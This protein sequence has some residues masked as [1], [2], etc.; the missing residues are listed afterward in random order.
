MAR[1]PVGDGAADLVFQGAE[2]WVINHR[3]L[4]LVRI[5]TRAATARTLAVIQATPRS[6][7]RGPGRP[8]IT[9][10]G[11]GLIQVDPATGAPVATVGLGPAGGIDVIE[12]AGALWV[13]ARA[14]EA[15]QSGFPRLG[16]VVRVDPATRATTTIS[17]A[18]GRLD[19]HGLADGGSVLWLADNTNGV[20]YRLP[21]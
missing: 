9:G 8:W 1:I 2:C 21:G 19:V 11:T 7:W 20:L 6:G 16:A 4:K 3:D 10:R 5:D 15:T 14:S 17:T 12:H 13:P 18:S